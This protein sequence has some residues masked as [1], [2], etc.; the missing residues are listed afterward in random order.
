[1]RNVLAFLAALVLVFLGLGWYFNWYQVKAVPTG[2]GHQSYTIDIDK[3]KIGKD[4]K[5]FEQSIEK[6]RQ[7]QN[8]GAASSR[9]DSASAPSDGIPTNVLTKTAEELI[10]VGAGKSSTSP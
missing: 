3:A 4:V 7:E 5:T 8:A 10:G 6:K 1:M 9:N 2:Q